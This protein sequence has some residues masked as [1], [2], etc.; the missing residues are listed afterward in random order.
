MVKK[1]KKALDGEK[2]KLVRRSLPYGDQ[3]ALRKRN[4]MISLIVKP[5]L[6]EN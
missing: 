5:T 6:L 3:G 2:F 4:A 1:K